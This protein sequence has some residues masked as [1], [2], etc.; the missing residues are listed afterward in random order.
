MYA[1]RLMVTEVYEAERSL[2]DGR[3]RETHLGSC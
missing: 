3:G 1:G 2:A